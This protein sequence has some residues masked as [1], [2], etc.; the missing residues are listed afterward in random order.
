M[1]IKS[2][3]I[4]VDTGAIV[5]LYIKDDQFH[6]E[7]VNFWK[8]AESEKLRL[9]TSNFVFNEILTWVLY[10]KGIVTSIKLGEYLLTNSDILPI[11]PILPEDEED[12]WSLYKKYYFG[13]SYTDC[14]SF[15]FMKRFGLRTAFSFDNHF[16][17][18]GFKI[19]P[20]L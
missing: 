16:I 4:F 10:K 17:Q 5:A 9:L 2:K 18:A 11:K 8:Y 12:A 1:D 13:V 6:E 19:L 3:A 7:A 14:T 15:A 20:E